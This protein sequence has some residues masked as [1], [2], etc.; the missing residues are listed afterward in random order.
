[1]RVEDW[2]NLDA[3]ERRMILCRHPGIQS[4]IARELG[5][6]TATVSLVWRGRVTSARVLD[7]ILKEVKP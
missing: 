3:D 4:K 5:V 2:H 6:S 7:A 1:M